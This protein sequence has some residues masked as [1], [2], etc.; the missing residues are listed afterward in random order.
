M[1]DVNFQNIEA[2][3]ADHYFR[4]IFNDA[5]AF[6][7]EWKDTYVID[8]DASRGRNHSPLDP[9]SK[10]E[11]P[12]QESF[13]FTE[14]FYCEE[15]EVSVTF[16]KTSRPAKNGE[17]T[18]NDRSMKFVGKEVLHV[19]R[20][21]DKIF[22]LLCVSSKRPD[23]AE[24]KKW[25]NSHKSNMPVYNLVDTAKSAQANVNIREII[26]DAQSRIFGSTAR[27]EKLLRQVA[28]TIGIPNSDTLSIAEVKNSLDIMLFTRDENQNYKMDL[29]KQFIG[30]TNT[31]AGGKKNE[32]SLEIGALIQQAIDV[33]LIRT[34]RGSKASG[35][36]GGWYFVDREG[37]LLD[38]ICSVPVGKKPNEILLKFLESSPEVL[39][40]LKAS[41]PE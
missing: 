34:E 13:P 31:G 26:T 35:L 8:W 12:A 36:P 16:Y 11:Y 40:N 33:K 30:L 4:K 23:L 20:N 14:T 17:K 39:K 21:L 9:K 38:F 15:G 18:Y 3:P 24:L 37:K 41:M 25:Q 1:I 5:T 10:I 2:L 6:L 29:I 27:E 32:Q 19:N 28:G 7:K 22:F